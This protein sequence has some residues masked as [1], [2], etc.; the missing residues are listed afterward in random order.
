MGRFLPLINPGD[1]RERISLMAP[2]IAEDA[3]GQK[4]ETY[5]AAAVIWAQVQ[6][7]RGREYQAAAA[8]QN[9]P[10]VRFRIHWRADVL[11]TWRVRWRGKDYRIVSDPIDVNGARR[12]LELMA[13]GCE[14]SA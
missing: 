5:A 11:T 14:V 3:L 2:A 10:G 8:A 4:T 1:M 6:P 7:L 9:E 13:T 12:V